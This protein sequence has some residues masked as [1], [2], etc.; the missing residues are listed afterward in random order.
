[1]ALQPDPP[2]VSHKLV[3]NGLF[4]IPLFQLLRQGR[5]PRVGGRLVY[6]PSQPNM[7]SK[8]GRIPFRLPR[9]SLPAPVDAWS[10]EQSHPCQDPLHTTPTE[11]KM[12]GTRRAGPDILCTRPSTVPLGLCLS[13]PKEVS[14]G[15]QVQRSLVPGEVKSQKESGE[16]PS[17]WMSLRVST[18]SK[19]PGEEEWPFRSKRVI[20]EG[21]FRR[22]CPD[23]PPHCHHLP[24]HPSLQRLS[25]CST[26]FHVCCPS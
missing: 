25:G 8:P 2:G 5:Q 3:G 7:A 11:H 12:M 16:E 24:L 17:R 9:A 23:P 15:L 26:F 22:A 13:K 21:F 6:Q 20:A 10:Q 19:M 4:L 1:M 14:M 18:V